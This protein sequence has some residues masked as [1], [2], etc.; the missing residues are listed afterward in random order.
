MRPL[1]VIMWW[2]SC[3]NDI[4]NVFWWYF[5]VIEYG[6]VFLP[7]NLELKYSHITISF[8]NIWHD[9]E[10]YIPPYVSNDVLHFSLFYHSYPPVFLSMLFLIISSINHMIQH[11]PYVTEMWKSI[12]IN[13]KYV[14]HCIMFPSYKMWNNVNIST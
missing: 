11:D 7:I 1:Q 9:L 6:S 10:V 13:I 2:W 4:C 8:K 3:S 12:V 14:I 5:S